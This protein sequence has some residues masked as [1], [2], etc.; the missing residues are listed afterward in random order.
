MIILRKYIIEI[1]E[2]PT[3]NEQKKQYKG[4]LDHMTQ[5]YDIRHMTV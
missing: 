1:V 2:K 3:K 4:P 5:P